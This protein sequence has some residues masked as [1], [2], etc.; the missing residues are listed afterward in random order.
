MRTVIDDTE[1]D[2]LTYSPECTLCANLLDIPK[3]TCL[4]F[5]NGIPLEIWQGDVKHRKLRGDEV[6]DV[7]FEKEK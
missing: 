4:A 5:P 1:F 3:R 2:I 7:T 6:M